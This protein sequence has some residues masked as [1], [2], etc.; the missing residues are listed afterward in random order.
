VRIELD[1]FHVRVDNTAARS[2]TTIAAS[3]ATSS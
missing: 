3:A 2:S 1:S